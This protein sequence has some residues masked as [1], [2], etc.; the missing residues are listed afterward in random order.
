MSESRVLLDAATFLDSAHALRVESAC[1]DD[2]REITKRFLKVAYED[3]GK[4]PRQLHGDE[5]QTAICQM[6]P[7]HFGKKDPLAQAVPD[8]LRAYLDHLQDTGI[9]S[10]HYELKQAV[11]SSTE[12]FLAAVA[13]G[14]A[15][16][17]GPAMAEKG[18]PFVHRA[19]KTGRNDPCP[20]GSG[21]KLKKC[22]GK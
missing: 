3:I 13:S 8:V 11:E 20:C 9:L 6:L 19:S 17:Q 4:A 7:R 12:Q 18:T 16:A 5:L 10:H 14:N 15:H 21:K 2:I 22:C 1:T